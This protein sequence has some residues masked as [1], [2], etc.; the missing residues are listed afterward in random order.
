M[1]SILTNTMSHWRSGPQP[2]KYRG[3][4]W[5]G[6]G[7]QRLLPMASLPSWMEARVWALRLVRT[8]VP[9]RKLS[10]SWHMLLPLPHPPGGTRSRCVLSFHPTPS[11]P[12][13]ISR[14]LTPRCIKATQVPPSPPSSILVQAPLPRSKPQWPSDLRPCSPTGVV[15]PPLSNQNFFFIEN[16]STGTLPE[17]SAL[18]IPLRTNS[19]QFHISESPQCGPS[20]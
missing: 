17:T 6:I 9:K 2:L 11:N 19:K 20:S 16:L 7:P 5:R 12:P 1:C 3:K 13:T 10:R 18:F 15:L 4:V 8:Q 14:T